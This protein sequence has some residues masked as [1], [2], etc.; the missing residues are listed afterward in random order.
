MLIVIATVA[1]ADDPPVLD[2]VPLGVAL[3]RE[4]WTCEVPEVCTRS[5]VV[6][7]YRGLTSAK[8][9]AEVVEFVWFHVDFATRDSPSPG[10]S[11]SWGR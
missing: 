10:T 8:L 9:H 6:A 5:G 11:I 1:A 7:G 3:D 4:G 2:G